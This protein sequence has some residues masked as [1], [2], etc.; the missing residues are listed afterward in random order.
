MRRVI[1]MA[2]IGAI[3][4]GLVV[5]GERA[6]KA[7]TH[8]RRLLLVALVATAVVLLVGLL[9]GKPASAAYPGGNGRI[10]Y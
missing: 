7:A 8:T 6:M 10:A 2:S 9:D 4:L 3:V 5:R 1:S